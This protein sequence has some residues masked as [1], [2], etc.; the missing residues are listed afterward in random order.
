MPFTGRRPKAW[1]EP[2]SS[3]V[4]SP[5]LI[6]RLTSTLA[7]IQEA[8]AKQQWSVPAEFSAGMLAVDGKSRSGCL[9]NGLRREG[10][11]D[12]DASAERGALRGRI[13]A[14]MGST[15]LK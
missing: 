15:A 11:T 2:L 13:P 1:A 6:A 9:R 4:I 7:E 8:K 14:R 5:R 12:G 3:G 10:E